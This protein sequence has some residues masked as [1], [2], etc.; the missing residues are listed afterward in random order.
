MSAK[1]EISCDGCGKADINYTGNSVD[2]YVQLANVASAPWFAKDPNSTGG[3]VTD[4]MIY[5]PIRGG[6]KHFC[7]VGCLASWMKKTFPSQFAAPHEG[8]KQ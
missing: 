1:T 8:E 4:R 7:G 5:P 6:N 2:Y 3:A